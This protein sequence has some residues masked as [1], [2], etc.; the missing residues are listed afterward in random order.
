MS[1][2]TR[3][4]W[5]ARQQAAEAEVRTEAN[6]R[7]FQQAQVAMELLTTSPEWN[8]YLSLVQERINTT[9][10]DIAAAHET[11]EGGPISSKLLALH[12]A[13]LLRLCARRD[14]LEEALALPATLLAAAGVK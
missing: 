13:H 8:A 14:A 1:T 9:K 12:H 11:L 6:L 3:D 10:A 5:M 4:Q 2:L 7:L